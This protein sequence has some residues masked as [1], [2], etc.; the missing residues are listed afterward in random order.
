[1]LRSIANG[2]IYRTAKQFFRFLEHVQKAGVPIGSVFEGAIRALNS[3]AFD[4]DGTR[5]SLEIERK[6]VLHA[7]LQVIAESMATD[8]FARSRL[9]Q[10]VNVLDR[11]YRA[12]NISR[13]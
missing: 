11:A 12:E 9:S 13:D 10:R 7:A 8:G 1:M 4:V 5:S 3:R 6:D 2:D